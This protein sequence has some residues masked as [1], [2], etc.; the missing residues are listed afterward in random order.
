MKTHGR[1]GIKRLVSMAV[2]TALGVAGRKRKSGAQPRKRKTKKIKTD[3]PLKVAKDVSYTKTK[4]KKK[5]KLLEIS[6]HNDLS[7]RNLGTFWPGKKWFP[8]YKTI[9]KSYY[10]DVSNWVA[11]SLQGEQCVDSIENILT[12]DMI[13]GLTTSARN[14]RQRIAVD[15][16]YLAVTSASGVNSEFPDAATAQYANDVFHVNN[17][18]GTVSM[19]S[20]ETIPQEVT[21]YFLTPRSDTNLDP[22]TY[23]S[24]VVNAHNMGAAAAGAATSIINPVAI[25][26]GQTYTDV[27]NNPF[28]YPEFRSLWRSVT[29]VKVILQPGDQHNVKVDFQYNRRFY[30]RE[31]QARS[32]QYLAGITIF[33]MVIQKGGLVGLSLTGTDGSATEVANGST[34]VGYATNFR[35]NLAALP[36]NRFTV[37]AFFPGNVETTTDYVK[38]IDDVDNVVNIEK[39]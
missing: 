26:G 12:R 15:L 8:K 3:A 27:G 4:T 21:V 38:Q 33:P 13:V 34:K 31:F 23:F 17:V 14:N 32:E 18:V 10:H 37:G 25:V 16:Y 36:P 2:A 11:T 29:S 39:I 19:L 28:L 6:Q 22:V 30:Y 24:Q 7:V 9:G 20:M 5:S 1:P 35:Y